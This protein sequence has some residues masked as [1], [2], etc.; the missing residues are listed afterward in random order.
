MGPLDDPE[1][2]KI[3]KTISMAKY[4]QLEGGKGGRLPISKKNRPFLKGIRHRCEKRAKSTIS[5]FAMNTHLQ[6]TGVVPEW[7][8]QK[9]CV[10][11]DQYEMTAT[12]KERIHKFCGK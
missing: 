1:F 11:F 7:N 5:C 10:I 12:K 6:T 4:L 9:N 2:Q 8:G 3:V